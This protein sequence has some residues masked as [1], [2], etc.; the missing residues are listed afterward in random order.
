MSDHDEDAIL[1]QFEPP[2]EGAPYP[3]PAAVA[4][5]LMDDP[6]HSH[7]AE[8]EVRILWLFRN[9]EELKGGKTVLGAVHEPMVQGRLRDLFA[10]ML[11]KT[12]GFMPDFIVTLSHDFW[13]DAKPFQREALC[14]HELSHI[15]QAT[16]KFG[17]PRVNRQTGEPVFCL[18]EHDLAEFNSTVRRYGAWAPDVEA[19][20]EAAGR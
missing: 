12:F 1:D 18:V 16:D 4:A 8:H 14:H 17:E 10:Q 15:K 13:R 6:E 20:L 2:A 19:F 9:G 5:M 3:H 11:V 7:L